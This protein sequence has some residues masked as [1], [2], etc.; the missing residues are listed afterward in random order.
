MA[1]DFRK[2]LIRGETLQERARSQKPAR[3]AEI[4]SGDYFNNPSEQQ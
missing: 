3:G 1:K 2:I 4:R